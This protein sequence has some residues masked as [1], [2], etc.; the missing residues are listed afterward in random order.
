MNFTPDRLGISNPRR[1]LEQ[2]ETRVEK[3]LPIRER[4][5]INA[6]S[7]DGAGILFP[8]VRPAL[9][10]LLAS[11][12]ASVPRRAHFFGGSS[13]RD[14]LK[15]FEFHDIVRLIVSISINSTYYW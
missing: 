6:Q 13:S 2:A 12:L 15:I 1:L 11:V 4:A 7:L 5:I 9:Q 10:S 3:F 14:D 8:V